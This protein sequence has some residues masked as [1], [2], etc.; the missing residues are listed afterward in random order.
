MHNCSKDDVILVRYPFTNLSTLKVRPA[1]VV[2]TVHISEDIFVVP[3]TSKIIS[4]LPGEFVLTDWADAG[5]NVATAV[6]RGIYTV[7]K[8]LIIKKVGRLSNS[9]TKSLG[10]SLRKW[11]GL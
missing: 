1:V 6:K 7:G 3:L 10:G 8:G 9:D 5:L 2:N 11:L 4:L